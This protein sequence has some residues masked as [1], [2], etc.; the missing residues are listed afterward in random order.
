MNGLIAMRSTGDDA[1]IDPAG[2]ELIVPFERLFYL[3]VLAGFREHCRHNQSW[4][5]NA[6]PLR[7]C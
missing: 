7:R 3:D 2:T 4:R 5:A 1:D 6:P